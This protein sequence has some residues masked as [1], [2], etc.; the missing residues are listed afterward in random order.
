MPNTKYPRFFLSIFQYLQISKVIES[1]NLLRVSL[2]SILS[3]Y[4]CS[5][6]TFK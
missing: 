5:T 1:D 2:R 6:Y 4:R 3:I